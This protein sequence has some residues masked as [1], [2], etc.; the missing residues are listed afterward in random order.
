MMTSFSKSGVMVS[1]T[2]YLVLLVL[3]GLAFST[4]VWSFGTYYFVLSY[5]CTWYFDT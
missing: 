4:V 2:K 1:S 5:F 3:N